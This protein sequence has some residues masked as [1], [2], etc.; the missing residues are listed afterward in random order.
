MDV[1]HLEEPEYVQPQL[2]KLQKRS[3]YSAATLLWWDTWA[4]S[5]QAEFFSPTDWL[6]LQ[7]MAPLVESYFRRPGHNALA[8]IRQNESLLGAT[9][10]D[11]MRL[12]MAALKDND[13]PVEPPPPTV[14][15]D[16][17]LYR[18]LNQ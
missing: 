17:E 6:R 10:T 3:T 16:M 18:E 8:E 4:N 1:S 15:I 12:R 14:E 9:I 7:M 13:K 2:K 5:E 11:R